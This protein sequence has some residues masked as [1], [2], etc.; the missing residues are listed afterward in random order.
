MPALTEAPQDTF[1]QELEAA[2]AEFS[3]DLPNGEKMW[4]PF[5]LNGAAARPDIDV[6]DIPEGG[7]TS[8]EKFHETVDWIISNEITDVT[9]DSIRLS[10]VDG[11]LPEAD[12][13][14]TGID[15]SGFVFFSLAR[16]IGLERLSRE[17][18]VDPSGKTLHELASEHE[19][20]GGKYQPHRNV[21]VARL[22][23][24]SRQL[25]IDEP[26]KAGDIGVYEPL[27][28]GGYTHIA[29]VRGMKGNRIKF[30]HSGRRDPFQEV[31]GVSLFSLPVARLSDES[32]GHRGAL[33]IRR[34]D[35]L[36]QENIELEEETAAA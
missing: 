1:A 18:N 33:Q 12:R 15:C 13:N 28:I 6:L 19:E 25:D 32:H 5:I 4:C 3:Y 21:S 23:L 22:T 10:M 31:G 30:A 24:S 16:V 26:I 20:N 35:I 29:L 11:S 2:V 8:A 14:Y 7:R 17:I 34:L 27:E 9:A 36:D